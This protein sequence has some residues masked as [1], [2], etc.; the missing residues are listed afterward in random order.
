MHEQYQ[1]WLMQQ[2]FYPV[3]IYQHGSQLFVREND[4][5][6]ILAVQVGYTAFVVDMGLRFC[7]EVLSS[8]KTDSNSFVISKGEKVLNADSQKKICLC[9]ILKFKD[10]DFEVS[11]TCAKCNCSKLPNE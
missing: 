5:Y 7:R 3:L 8:A 11:V 2:S 6:R 9:E 1:A 4:T 10:I